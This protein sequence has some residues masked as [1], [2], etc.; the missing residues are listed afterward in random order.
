MRCAFRGDRFTW[1][2]LR[3]RRCLLVTDLG[4][5]PVAGSDGNRLVAW[6]DGTRDV[7]PVRTLRPLTDRAR[8]AVR[9]GLRGGRRAPT[10]PSEGGRS[11]GLT[12]G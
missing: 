2:D 7:V 9:A 11:A 10:P 12:I 1:R 4:G 8:D 3:G 6:E 5:Q